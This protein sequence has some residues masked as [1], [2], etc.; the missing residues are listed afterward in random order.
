MDGQPHRPLANKTA[1][2]T[3]SSRG[4]SP[5]VIV[6]LLIR[7]GI[8]RAIA[9]SLAMQGARVVIHGTREDS[10]TTFQEGESMPLLANEIAKASGTKLFNTRFQLFFNQSWS[11]GTTNPRRQRGARGVGRSDERGGSCEA[12]QRY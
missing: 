7:E 1:W 4:K 5:V 10:P 12:P 3:G 9:E 8:G 2:V 11:E 6:F